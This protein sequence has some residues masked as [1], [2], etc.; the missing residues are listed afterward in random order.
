M[1]TGYYLALL[2]LKRVEAMATEIPVNVKPLNQP[3]YKREFQGREIPLSEMSTVT[4]KGTK[5]EYGRSAG[6]RCA[7]RISHD[8][9]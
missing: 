6:R 1:K 5:N 8:A 2:M 3:Q 9:L 7:Q 4:A